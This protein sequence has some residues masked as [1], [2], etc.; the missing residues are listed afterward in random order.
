MEDVGVMFLPYGEALIH[1]YYFEQMER[2]GRQDNIRFL[3]CQTNLSFDIETLLNYD[4]NLS[5]LKL[6]CSFHPSQTSVERFI[7]QCDKLWN[8]GIVFSVGAVG[9]PELLPVLRELRERLDARIYLW[10][11]DMDGKKRAY[12]KAEIA[13]FSRIDPLFHLE[14]KKLPADLGNCRSGKDSFFVNGKGDVYACNISKVLMGNIYEQELDG[15]SGRGCRSQRCS[16][17]LAY[18]NRL[19]LEQV[20]SM[21]G[22]D[23]SFRIPLSDEWRFRPEL[24]GI[25]AFFFDVDGTLTDEWGNISEPTQAVIQKLAKTCSVY[26]ATSL[27]Y[28]EARRKC[29]KI[30]NY[31]D[32]GAF[33]EGSDIRIFSTGYSESIPLTDDCF[34]RKICQANDCGHDNGH[35]TSYNTGLVRAYH[36]NGVLH[37]ITLLKPDCKSDFKDYYM[38][39]D[40]YLVDEGGR[41]GITDNKA[42]KLQ[43][44]L[45]ICS[46][47]GYCNEDVA[48]YGNSSNDIE[49]I[50][51]FE[52]SYTVTDSSEAVKAAA[53]LVIDIDRLFGSSIT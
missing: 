22:S 42:D 17:Y 33:A 37:K 48:V 3:A 52:H 25:K 27:P 26:L 35:N 47:K 11:N 23:Y 45:R 10:I 8:Y 53:G 7:S 41:I 16:C 46:E 32:G 24:A 38:A 6:W 20:R 40:Y 34:G 13:A 5:K 18:S 50:K 12:T 49:L 2:L 31:L 9:D 30:W 15:M 29:K 28:H 21:F 44:V 19:D 39:G 14:L 1:S 51:Y 36:K 43:A 4:I